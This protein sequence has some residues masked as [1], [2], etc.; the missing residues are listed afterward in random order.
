[1]RNLF[2]EEDM[3]S[4]DSSHVD[5]TDTIV[6]EE[7]KADIIHTRLI[8]LQLD[9]AEKL[10]D[11]FKE[12][13]P[14]PFGKAWGTDADYIKLTDKLKSMMENQESISV[15]FLLDDRKVAKIKKDTKKKQLKFKPSKF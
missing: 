13:Q 14:Q 1:M 2:K 12:Y 6:A 15:N 11:I 8:E 10:R 9:N 3:G 4:V 5:H 7:K